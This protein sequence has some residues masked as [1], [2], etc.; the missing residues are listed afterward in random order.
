MVAEI[1]VSALEEA[2]IKNV[3]GLPGG[4]AVEVLDSIRRSEIDFTLVHH[5]TS[6]AFMASA[7]ARLTGSPSACLATLGPG[8]TNMVTG[9]AHAYLDRAP[10]IAI[11]AETPDQLLPGH[12]HQVL[13]LEAIFSPITK[14]SIRVEPDGAGEMV[15]EAIALAMS[16]RPGPVH[17]R[18]SGDVAAAAASA[19]AA[20]SKPPVPESA[21]N[22][23]FQNARRLVSGSRRPILVVG[24]GLEPEAPYDEL[25]YFAEAA[26]AP[27][28]V[29][30]KAKGAIPDD[31]PLVAGCIGL[32]RTDPVYEIL[33]QAD[34][35]IAAGFDAVEL[36]KP[37]EHPA[38]LVWIA[39]WA[40]QNSLIRAEVEHNGPIGPML[41]YLAESKSQSEEGWGVE[42]VAAHRLTNPTLTSTVAASE[43]LVPQ[44][45]L[46][47][48]R[49]QLER[50]ALI[51]TDVGSHKILACLEWPAF[52]PNRFLVSNGLS[53]MGYSLS[54]AIA[55]GLALHE[56]SI[57]CTV[58]DAG[59][60]MSMGELA[61]LARLDLP[62]TVVVFKDG[63]LDL[64]RS[65][66][67]RV[68]KPTFGTE[69]AAPNFV[70]VAGAYGI[71][72]ESVS[73]EKALAQSVK[74]FVPSKK[75]A[76]IEAKIDPAS[77]PPTPN[78]A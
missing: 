20:V 72:A 76:L 70:Q 23:V 29:T 5:E 11:S 47:V 49:D 21:E 57:V 40:N 3:F 41:Q 25:L 45:V 59:L 7:T 68:G 73:S 56:T 46:R 78:V 37:W 17:L 8:S 27:V 60:L 58:G 34:C 74:R 4:E 65:H 55:A 36:V 48:L 62:V 54:A 39:P 63:A 64:I 18:I 38:P 35:V 9:V 32:T 42:I 16:G 44:T 22:D 15:R 50:D 2:G 19:T 69:F 51:T 66:Q 28:I 10:V 77:Y 12:T 71:P 13:D 61:T 52:I 53:S 67:N 75:P 43:R 24:L 26:N 14:A 33:D 1:L 30:P 6:A 31:H